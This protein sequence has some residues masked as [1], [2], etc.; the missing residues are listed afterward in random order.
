M[1][2]TVCKRRYEYFGLLA[3]II[4]K[5]STNDLGLRMVKALPF[6]H[7][8]NRVARKAC[9]VSAADWRY[10]THVKKYLIF[11]VCCYNFSQGW[12]SLYNTVVCMIKTINS[13]ITTNVSLKATL[14][15]QETYLHT[16]R[17]LRC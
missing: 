14:N 13:M 17:F 1:T 6:I 10:Q 2:D 9:D 12:K 16:I 15:T 4:R 8:P 3:D 7:Q 5:Y 11:P